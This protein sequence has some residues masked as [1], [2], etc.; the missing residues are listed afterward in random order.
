MAEAE[1]ARFPAIPVTK[2]SGL[3]VFRVDGR[4][5]PENLLSFWQWSS[6]DLVGNALRGVLAEYIVATAVGCN[7]GLRTEWDAFD[8]VTPDGIKIEV[9]SAA[10]IQSWTQ[11]KLSAIQFGIRPTQSLEAGTNQY[12]K[13]IERQSDVYVFCVLTQQ[14]QDAIDPLNLDQWDFYVISTKKLDASVGSQ[15]SIAL[16]R[17]KQLGP[18][19]AAFSEIRAAISKVLSLSD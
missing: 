5:L 14:D 10:Y 16:A 7:R 13:K 1:P 11:A 8:M 6:S 2:K 3:E 4:P 17:L 15:K 12:S 9:K 18:V 19:V